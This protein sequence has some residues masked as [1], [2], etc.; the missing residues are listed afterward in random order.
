MVQTAFRYEDPGVFRRIP[1]P[2]GDGH[3]LNVELSGSPTGAPII[4]CHGGPGGQI[5]SHV[6]RFANPETMLL[7]QFDQRGC[8]ASTP[9]G[10]TDANTTDHLVADMEMIRERLGLERWAIAGGSWGATLALAYAQVHPGRTSGVVLRGAFL[11]SEAAFRWFD[12]T[13]REVFPDAFEEYAR[14]T[15]CAGTESIYAA[16]ARHIGGPDIEAA[17][18]AAAALTLYEERCATLGPQDEAAYA[19]DAD[20]CLPGIKVALHYHA[21][22]AF[23]PADGVLPGMGSL[24]GVPGIIVHGRYDVIC[25]FGHGVRLHRA[26]PGSK[27]VLCPNSGHLGTEPEMIVAMTEAF[28]EA[29]RW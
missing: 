17:R 26:W 2:V 16:A 14:Q 3:S 5:G 21:H 1:L 9:A 20:A 22:Q 15:G 13:M 18:R 23:L 12:F 10:C 4:H 29:I 6:R 28:E 27:L 8:G 11:G 24:A 25:P 7:V 19:F